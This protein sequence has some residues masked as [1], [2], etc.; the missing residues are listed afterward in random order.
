M[1]QFLEQAELGN[2]TCCSR[3]PWNPKIVGP[4]AFGMSCMEHG[5]NFAIASSAISMQVVQDP[6]GTTPEKTGRLC[7][8]HNSE[9][10]TDKTALH[11]FDLWKATVSFD[12]QEDQDPY[13]HNHYW[14][15][16]LLHG[17][18][19]KTQKHLRQPDVRE[20]ARRLFESIK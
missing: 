6:A 18:N 1:L 16:A 3:C 11:A 19:K 5:V 20:K 17:A 13:L 2:H 10:Q 14:T 12:I 15:N 9:Y 8:V 4:I 7:F